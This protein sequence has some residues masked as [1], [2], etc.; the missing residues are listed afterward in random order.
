MFE[1][2]CIGYVGCF[3][4]L[5][6]CH[7]LITLLWSR[8]WFVNVSLFLVLALLMKVFFGCFNYVRLLLV[9]CSV[10]VVVKSWNKWV[11]LKK[12]HQGQLSSITICGLLFRKSIV[13]RHLRFTTL[14]SP[15]FYAFFDHNRF[16]IKLIVYIKHG[17]E[18]K[19]TIKHINVVRIQ[20]VTL[21]FNKRPILL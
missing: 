9:N 7:G 4:T 15:I 20:G 10:C 6:N 1:F 14:Y 17:H 11:F 2:G 3:V 16:K 8:L 18:T 21:N 12:F 19:N 5:N 13:W